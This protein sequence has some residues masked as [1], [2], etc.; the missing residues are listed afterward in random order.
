[1]ELS[2]RDLMKYGVLG[3]A[4]LLLPIERVARTQLRVNDRMPA[5]GL[6][7]PYTLPFQTSPVPT[8]LQSGN[9]DFYYLHMRAQKAAV[10]GP[11]KPLTTIWGYAI[12]DLA[13][14]VA[15]ATTPGPTI[16]V[17]RG[18]RVAVRHFQD[19]P[20][21]HPDQLY[22]STTSVHLHG[23]GSLPQFD[24]YASDTTATGHFKDYHYPNHQ[25]ARTLWYHDHGIHH[26]AN[27]A[28]MGLAAQYHLHDDLERR[29]GIPVGE[30]YDVPLTIRDAMFAKNGEL[31]YDDNSES[32]VYGDVILVNGVPWPNMRVYKR[33][34]RFRILN[35]GLSRS[36][37]LRLSTG[38]P[39]AVIGT[40]GGLMNAP[41]YVS[42]FRHGMAER[43]EVIIDFAKYKVG[44]KVQLLNDSPKNNRD[45]DTTNKVM[46]FEVVG[47]APT[48]PD[49]R[50]PNNDLPSQLNDNFD[51]TGLTAKDAKVTRKFAFERK[52]GHWTINGETW[53]DVIA[54]GYTHTVAQPRVG[55]VEIWELENKS[56]GW[57][58]PIH[59]HLID[60]KIL[61]RNGKAPF[62][63]E[64]GPKDVAYV[65]ENE[66]VRVIMKFDDTR[67]R[68]EDHKIQQRANPEAAILPP[69]T[70]RYMM[71]CH[72][73]VHEDHDMMV[74]F[75]VRPRDGSDDP[76]PG[77]PWS[78]GREDK[79]PNEDAPGK[80]LE[81]AD[82]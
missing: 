51:V 25:D 16:H 64:R 6:P 47:D 77:D 14:N 26:T 66:K 78:P 70:G 5:S 15:P 33:K 19:L 24:G 80:A 41:A 57:F 32:G 60:F 11:G 65:G 28:Y 59:I 68:N 46:Q 76:L 37:N 39:F 13:G 42:S 71:H 30:P 10:L 63:Y 8:P 53:E 36:Y 61:D 35:A 72:N 23:S 49:G 3:S 43:Y 20:A 75:E 2:R 27:N 54:S 12:G 82:C 50:I 79:D 48:G 29:L 34:Y 7:K 9:T 58:H 45:F 73:L 67:G 44:Q 74:Q 38:E 1:M 21:T 69:R 56:G 62:A 52:H 18:R 40:D 22:P 55:D 4:A 17:E 81:E 31:I